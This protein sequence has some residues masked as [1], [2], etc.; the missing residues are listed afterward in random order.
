MKRPILW[1]FG[2][3]V[4]GEILAYRFP[5]VKVI[6]LIVAAVVVTWLLMWFGQ[7]W[8]WLFLPLFLVCG[9]VWTKT[10]IE[11]SALD[12]ALKKTGYTNGRY[13]GIVSD[14]RQTKS[15]WKVSVSE[16]TWEKEGRSCSGDGVLIYMEETPSFFPGDVILMEGTIEKWEEATN[17]GQFDSWHYYQ[18]MGLDGYCVSARIKRV[19]VGKLWVAKVAYRIRRWCSDQLDAIRALCHEKEWHDTIGMLQGILLGERG[20]VPDEAEEALKL[21]GLSHILAISGLH[22]SLVG[23]CLFHLMKQRL[24]L[25]YGVSVFV[26]LAAVIGY[27]AIAG[28]TAS[29][30]RAL[31]MFGVMLVGEMQARPY[32][33]ISA[34][35]LAGILVL[36]DRP[37]MLFQASFQLSFA[38]VLGIGFLYPILEKWMAPTSV[39]KTCLMTVSIQIATLP[40]LAWHFYE[41]AFAGFVLNGLILPLMPFL[42]GAGLVG[43]VAG[44]LWPVAGAVC[45]MPVHIV[46]QIMQRLSLW[47]GSQ[48][49]FLWCIGRPQW[50]VVVGYG[51]FWCL[52]V[53]L[54]SRRK[55]GPLSKMGKKVLMMLV[56]AAVLSLGY[57]P[58]QDLHMIFLDVGQGDGALILFPNGQTML[59]DGGS[60]DIKEVGEYRLLPCLRYYGI[61]HL[62]YV[63]VSHLDADHSNGIMW[64]LKEGFSVG[65]VVVSDVESKE[66]DRV[67]WRG[68]VET[69]G[70]S[71]VEIG[72][73][74][75]AKI[76]QVSI[77]CLY[78]DKGA[79]VITE[80]DASLVL[81]MEYGTFGAL[82]TGDLSEEHEKTLIQQGTNWKNKKILLKVAHHGSKYSTGD[83]LLQA[84]KPRWAVLSCGKNSYGHPHEE[85]LARLEHASCERW[86]TPTKGA[87]FVTTDGNEVSMSAYC[88]SGQAV[89]K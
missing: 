37:L 46:L 40:V 43:M 8:R 58:Q 47:I 26:S 33:L 7:K 82:L 20:R 11:P 23:M 65:Q 10:A 66:A 34:C 85:V 49:G 68:F 51:V 24:A 22:I 1:A 32:D 80:N 2:A 73:G 55:K 72:A 14:L 44:G 21:G 42:T 70:I 74:G 48:T 86:D 3:S 13:Q 60:S 87:V 29:S 57:K 18:A 71:F 50:Y 79:E 36:A 31:C 88:A 39:W 53:W 69:K 76:G 19:D 5:E 17:P 16:I 25:P 56:F 59:V 75:S 28:K 27:C 45:L 41:V 77:R 84:L 64:L 30:A 12:H 54:G 67:L 9:F 89:I 61:D 35:S 38:A 4:L 78:P 63:V 83:A 81:W 15:G 52:L 62:D 6:W